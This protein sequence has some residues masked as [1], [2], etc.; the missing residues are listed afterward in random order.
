MSN[1]HDQHEH[2]VRR[3]PGH[4]RIWTDEEIERFADGAMGAEDAEALRASL[5]ADPEIRAGLARVQRTDALAGAVLQ[6][7]MTGDDAGVAHAMDRIA[8][9]AVRRGLALAACILALLAGAFAFGRWSVKPTPP[10]APERL[11]ASTPSQD[12]SPALAPVVGAGDVTPRR[13][14]VRIVFEMPFTPREP[15]PD[16]IAATSGRSAH[17]APHDSATIDPRLPDREERAV[18][19]ARE[20]EI[21]ALGRAIRS[22]DLARQTLDTMSGED[23]LNACRIW[24]RDPSLRPVAFERLA[25]LQDDPALAGAC[26][27]IA[28]E[29]SDDRSLLAWARSHGLRMSSESNPTHQ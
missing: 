15:A 23:Q 10:V 1:A 9:R 11:A 4:A 22:A 28:S 29:M 7:L 26:A 13:P 24:A 21:L 27:R 2:R 6:G 12:G 19:H 3:D 16:A 25:K 18:T 8:S 14:A 17:D 20:R 5:L